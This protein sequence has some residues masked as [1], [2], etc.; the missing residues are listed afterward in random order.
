MKRTVLDMQ[1]YVVQRCGG[2]IME[3]CEAVFNVQRLLA[4][5]GGLI[6]AER[7]LEA[8]LKGMEIVTGAL[9]GT[10]RRE[11]EK[12]G[13]EVLSRSIDSNA[14]TDERNDGNDGDDVHEANNES[15]EYDEDDFEEYGG[16]D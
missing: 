3:A 8:G 14:T 11:E 13:R 12:E 1:A 10:P 15:K 7:N 5:E 2:S 9:A 4:L 6:E 16:E